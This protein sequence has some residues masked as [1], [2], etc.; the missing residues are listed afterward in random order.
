MG[1]LQKG[2]YVAPS[3]LTGANSAI[4]LT[5]GIIF[6]RREL[7]FG[8]GISIAIGTFLLAMFFISI[9]VTRKIKQI[10]MK[11]GR[12]DRLVT[13]GPYAIVR[14]PNYAGAILM[15]LAFL[16]FFRTLW[17]VPVIGLSTW[18]WYLE[19]RYEERELTAKFGG[20]Y[21]NYARTT[22]MFL[23]KLFKPKA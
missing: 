21:E 6:S 5:V 2:F 18:L 11:P 12:V 20:L 10:H 15:N 3:I 16:C 17:L 19:A 1:L 22:G 9:Y 23:P 4:L 14:H 8:D 7:G 13:S